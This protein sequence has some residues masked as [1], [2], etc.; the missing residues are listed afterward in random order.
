[1][2]LIIEIHVIM[3]NINVYENCNTKRIKS[4]PSLMIH[5]DNQSEKKDVQTYGRGLYTILMIF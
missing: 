5:Q 2:N 4:A 3:A 1:M